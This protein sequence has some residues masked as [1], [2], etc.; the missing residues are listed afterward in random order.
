M[1]I[2]SWDD[3]DIKYPESRD[4]MTEKI[5]DAISKSMCRDRLETRIL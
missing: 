1:K 2:E 3:I 4:N 5:T